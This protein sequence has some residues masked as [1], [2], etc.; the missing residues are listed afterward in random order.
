M[1]LE[2]LSL[3]FFVTVLQCQKSTDFGLGSAIQPSLSYDWEILEKT[4]DE[5]IEL[6]KTHY[7][8]I[9]GGV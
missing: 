6:L 8:T 2:L 4:S 9:K 7:N 5:Y 1:I 3:L